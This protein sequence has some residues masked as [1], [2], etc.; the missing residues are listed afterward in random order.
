[1]GIM[2]LGLDNR[3]NFITGL[4]MLLVCLAVFLYS[5]SHDSGASRFADLYHVRFNDVSGLKTGNPVRVHGVVSGYVREMAVDGSHARVTLCLDPRIKVYEGAEVRLRNKTMLGGRFLELMP[6]DPSAAVQS[7]GGLLSMADSPVT[8]DELSTFLAGAIPAGSTLPHLLLSL[9]DKGGA[10]RQSFK[11]IGAMAAPAREFKENLFRLTRQ[12]KQGRHMI[13]KIQALD[14]EL[15]G[16]AGERLDRLSTRLKQLDLQLAPVL[17]LFDGRAEKRF[18]LLAENMRRLADTIHL[19]S[20]RQL[21]L[22]EN[23]DRTLTGVKVYD[24]LFLR[25]LFQ[26]DGLKALSLIDRAAIIERI[27]QLEARKD[28]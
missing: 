26:Q 21:R 25:L 7:P 17:R 10:L 8:P 14:L 2:R 28:P 22:I 3:R 11:G 27:R 4:L 12:L 20:E 15:S 18:S 24:Q 5:V 6:G 23:L 9:H 16:D 1:M 13:G 19:F